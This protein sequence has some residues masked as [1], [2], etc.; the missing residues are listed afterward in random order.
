MTFLLET[1]GVL[2][3]KMGGCFRAVAYFFYGTA[4]AWLACKQW[5]RERRIWAPA[6]PPRCN[7]LLPYL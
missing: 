5:S 1:G 2:T 7:V 6:A 3:R 4:F